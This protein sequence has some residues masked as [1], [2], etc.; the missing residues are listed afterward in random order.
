MLKGQNNGK[1][2]DVEFL[3]SIFNDVKKVP[4]SF[5]KNV[6]TNSPSYWELLKQQDR[7][8]NMVLNDSTVT[9]NPMM[10]IKLFR[11]IW[12]QYA[13]IF[14]S[15]FERFTDGISQILNAY[16]QCASI[17]SYYRLHDILD[18]LVV[19][20]CN[21]IHYSQ[22]NGLNDM[23]SIESFKTLS[24][25]ISKHGAQIQEGWKWI[26]ELLL[27]LFRLDILPEEMRIQ[28]NLC[29][30]G[31]QVIIGP[32]MWKQSQHRNSSVSLFLK[33]IGSYES[34]SEDDIFPNENQIR[35]QREI[36]KKCKIAE[37]IDNSLYFSSQSFGYFLESFA[38]ISNDFIKNIYDKTT[39][40]AICIHWITQLVIINSERIYSYW[41]IINDLYSKVIDCAQLNRP[42]L[43]LF[44][45][46]IT[47]FFSLLNHFWGQEKFRKELSNLF[48][49]I[50]QLEQKILE[51]L[52]PELL[53]GLN[54]FFSIHIVSFVSFHR[55]A[56]ALKILNL[57]FS[58]NEVST[59]DMLDL[60]IKTFLESSNKPGIE[61]LSDFYIP[62]I[63]TTVI[64]CIKNEN[65]NY[66][67]MLNNLQCI[68]CFQGIKEMTPQMWENIFEN[69]LFPA[70]SSLPAEVALQ[71][72]KTTN[73]IGRSIFM[74]KI[75]YRSFLLHYSLLAKLPN[76]DKIL[77]KLIQYSLNL[78]RMR[79]TDF[80]ES[81]PELLGNALIVLKNAG[82]FDSEDKQQSWIDSCEIIKQVFPKFSELLNEQK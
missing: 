78:T 4:L 28:K 70:F 74:V 68:L 29:K 65:D 25:I 49:K 3:S 9:E 45:R 66:Y 76:F 62:F 40:T 43:L 18:N 19:N 61:R 57:S 39:E 8:R 75:I 14:T 54:L 33:I 23:K 5:D 55:Y 77:F 24:L 32:Q 41:E 21:L 12:I 53:N 7:V 2:F 35:E 10:V 46:I 11:E 56:S 27:G 26:L 51:A 73:I 79:I 63:Q 13:P 15:L 81:I 48:E 22:K 42:M 59:F 71:K 52:L 17:A 1:D 64:Y 6:Q 30:E 80:N 67:K 69:V 20:I 34:E 36:L 58:R 60:L 72:K 82:I 16:F 44:Q 37:I 31:K 50:T 47:S 38:R